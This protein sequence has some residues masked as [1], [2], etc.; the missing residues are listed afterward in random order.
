MKP[1]PDWTP[2]AALAPSADG[3]LRGVLGGTALYDQPRHAE[4]RARVDAFVSGEG[5][6]AGPL[7]VEIGFDHGMRILDH[8]R[9]WPDT[10]WLGLE[11][12]KRR[13]AAAA[14]HAPPNCLL[15]RADARTVFTAVLPPASVAWVYIL[16]PTPT[17]NPRH[18][19]LTPTFV[20]AV[21]RVLAPKGAVYLATD[22]AGLHDHAAALLEGW[23]DAP[24]PP[25][26]PVLSRR[27]RVCA[28]DGLPVYRLCR[29]PPIE[30]TEAA[31]T[32]QE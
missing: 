30:P 31:W 14:P 8:A 15:W 17:D 13:V 11:I 1:P 27:E 21:R 32:G 6:V 18:L 28:R 2:P 29:T 10:R 26:G 4:V 7:A 5:M 25:M 22:V 3:Q 20:A 23:A 24:M 19:L 12:R 9:R 16:F